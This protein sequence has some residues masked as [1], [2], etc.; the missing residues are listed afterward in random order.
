[1]RRQ[2]PSNW[3]NSFELDT[4]TF[5][6]KVLTIPYGLYIFR[7]MSKYQDD[8]I[9]QFAEIFK[10]LSNPN[11]LRMFL[12]LVTCCVPGTVGSFDAEAGV[13]ACVGDLGR[14]LD[15]VPSTVSHHIKELRRAGLVRMERRGQ[16][17]ECWVDPVI[18]RDLALFFEEPLRR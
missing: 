11:R 7:Y 2:L 18:L 9:K 6:E 15:I 17:I 12:H 8:Q 10:A 4:H 13:S 5:E 3:P 1:V 14:D 16:K